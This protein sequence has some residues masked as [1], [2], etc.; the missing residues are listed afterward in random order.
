M[1]HALLDCHEV[2]LETLA[3]EMPKLILE[4]MSG[5]RC[6]ECGS[7]RELFVLTDR[8]NSLQVAEP[9]GQPRFVFFEDEHDDLR[10]KLGT[11][12]NAGWLIPV[13]KQEPPIYR[14]TEEFAHQLL[15][16]EIRLPQWFVNQ[17]LSQY[18]AASP[19]RH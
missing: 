8:A 14:M 3:A 4:M 9:T 18:A 16:A 19:P 13:S 12:V 15:A 10:G 17:R 2:R 1:R 7:M 6:Q 11:L 5:I